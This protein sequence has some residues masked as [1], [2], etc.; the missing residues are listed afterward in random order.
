[1]AHDTQILYVQLLLGRASF[2][3]PSG[4]R[5]RIATRPLSFPATLEHV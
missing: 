1:M 4:K 2:G 5:A 3:G